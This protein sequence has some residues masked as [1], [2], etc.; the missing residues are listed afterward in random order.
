MLT[1]LLSFFKVRNGLFTTSL[2]VSTFNIHSAALKQH[3][4]S[5][6]DL[7]EALLQSSEPV[8]SH[9]AVVLYRETF[10]RLTGFFQQEVLLE[11][12]ERAL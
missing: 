11:Q 4:S 1:S 3:F 7:S 12:Q 8:I 2:V 5:V 6:S 9:F 10:L